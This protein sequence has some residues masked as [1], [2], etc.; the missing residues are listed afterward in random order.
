[1]VGSFSYR[2]HFRELTKMIIHIDFQRLAGFL[3]NLP[4][5]SAINYGF[6][7]DSLPVVHV[8]FLF[9]ACFKIFM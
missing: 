3:F 1:M 5:V 8:F 9:L 4:N 7:T 2:Y 6:Y